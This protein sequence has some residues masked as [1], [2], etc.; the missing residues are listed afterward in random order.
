MC[1]AY[2][3]IVS[4][5]VTVA[6]NVKYTSLLLHGLYYNAGKVYCTGPG[7]TIK[8]KMKKRLKV[9]KSLQHCTN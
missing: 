8:E 2:S 1:V 5:H 4:L 6:Y 3:V 7:K 9:W